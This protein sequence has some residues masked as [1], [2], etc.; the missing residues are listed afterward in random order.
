MKKIYALLITMILLF[1]ACQP[2]PEE[3]IVKSKNKD[4]VSEVIDANSEENQEALEEDKEIIEQQIEEINRHVSLEHQINDRVKVI[5]DAEV[6]IPTYDKIPLVR[7]APENFTENHLKRLLE[8]VCGDNPVYYLNMNKITGACLTKEEIGE[9]LVI[10][11][12]F[13]QNENLEPLTKSNLE[14]TIENMEE[15]YPA[16]KTKSEDIPYEGGL[17]PDER[18]SYITQTELKCYLGRNGAAIIRMSQTENK[19]GGFIDVMN[20]GYGVA[21]NTFEPYEGADAEKID[22]PYEECRQMADDLVRAL[23]GGDTNMVHVSTNIG[24]AIGHFADHTKETAPQCY[25]FEFARE[26]NGVAVKYVGIFHQGN[27]VNYAQRV[28]PERI[29][30]IIDN[31]G[32]WFFYWDGYTKY[33]ETLT[34]DVPLMDF[35]SINDIFEDYCRYKFSWVPQYDSVPDDATVTI[36]IDHIELN[37]MM[38]PEKDNLDTYIMI[39]V[40]DYIGDIN[41]DQEIIT[42]DGYAKKGP[43]NVAVLTV[44]AIDGTIIDREQGY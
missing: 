9:I 36:N 43:Q 34:E 28:H 6:E 20:H 13:A 8:E 21:Y 10:L 23:D 42:Q 35:E 16:A 17:S 5:V 18:E 11:R 30:I 25:M 3:A 32:I 24:Y 2:T 15:R 4:L 19:T 38:T 12:G 27:N 33:L 40:W 1:A 14:E 29:S 22:M 7:V 44:N 41:Y 37:L 26:Y 31:E 39:P